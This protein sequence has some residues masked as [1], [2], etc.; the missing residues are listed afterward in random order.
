MTGY[1]W[2]YL[3]P[4]GAFG[5]L[6]N[7]D[8]HGVP[9]P[10]DTANVPYSATISGTGNVLTFGIGGVSPFAPT[11]TITANITAQHIGLSGTATAIVSGGTLTGTGTFTSGSNP[12]SVVVELVKGGS[13]V[14][15][16]DTADPINNFG[17]IVVNA[18]GNTALASSMAYSPFGNVGSTRSY[19]NPRMG[20]PG[21]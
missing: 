1:A 18:V 2:S 15:P 8:P 4:S 17:T 21:A 20:E 12:G 3:V 11:V 19:Q 9:G 6:S 14:G 10:G 13:L 5:D 7:C 16:A